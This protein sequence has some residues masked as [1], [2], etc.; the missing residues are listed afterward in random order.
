MAQGFHPSIDLFDETLREG[1]E[2]APISASIE[3]KCELAR[4]IANAGIRTIVVG[5]F[6]D[7]PHNIALL[8]ALLDEQDP[9]RCAS[10]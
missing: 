2:R 8:A 10:S 9:P 6:P 3:A 1:A 7:V 4:A 5:M